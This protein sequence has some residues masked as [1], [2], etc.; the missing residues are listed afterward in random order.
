MV[1]RIENRGQLYDSN[2]SKIKKD[3]TNYIWFDFALSEA[4]LRRIVQQL[5]GLTE[6]WRRIRLKQLAK[7]F[8]LS[9]D[10]ILFEARLYKKRQIK[11]LEKGVIRHYHRTSLDNFEIIVKT[12]RLL[13]RA[14]LKKENPGITI[15]GWSA[16]DN[17]MFTRDKYDKNWNLVV[18][19]FSFDEVVWAFWAAII[20]VFN[21]NIMNKHDYDALWQYPTVSEIW[22]QDYCEVILVEKKENVKL[23][24]NI[25]RKY[26]LDVKVC[27]KLDWKS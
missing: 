18:P 23:V 25:L 11:K 20:L 1:E 5:S 12:W 26:L 6:F 2:I 10:R 15:P 7:K 19:W 13:S 21:E 9:Y 24:E 27:Y 22:L 17:V 8:W 4:E 14:K 16:S 3:A